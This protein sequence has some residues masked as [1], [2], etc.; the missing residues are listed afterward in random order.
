MLFRSA[1]VFTNPNNQALALRSFGNDPQLV[2]S[3]VSA[4]V[5]GMRS[6]GVLCTLKHFPGHG[7]TAEDS[8]N[9]SAVISKTME[10]LQACDLIPFKAGIEAGAQFV[11]VGHLSIPAV[12]GNSN[13]ATL[14][15]EIVTDLLKNKLDFKGIIITD[16]MQMKAI[17]DHYSSSEAAVLAILAGNDMILMPENLTEA[18]EGIEKAIA[19]GVLTEDRINESVLKILTL[20]ISNKIIK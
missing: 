13:P 3:M 12:I 17:T 15:S 16:S 1:D 14:S 18:V 20:K 4:C 10:E 2:A 19:D 6:G 9:G 7:S 5:K 11:M 8:H